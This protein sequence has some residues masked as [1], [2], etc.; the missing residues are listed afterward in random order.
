MVLVL[1]C[2]RLSHMIGLLI[3]SKPSTQEN[4]NMLTHHITLSDTAESENK[5]K[6]MQPKLFNGVRLFVQDVP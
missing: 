5:I 3:Q 6:Y 2:R 4:K 1:W